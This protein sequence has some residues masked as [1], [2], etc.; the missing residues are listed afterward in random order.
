MSDDFAARCNAELAKFAAL[1]ARIT[2]LNDEL[3]H[4]IPLPRPPVDLRNHIRRDLFTTRLLIGG[5]PYLLHIPGSQ[6]TLADP[7]RIWLRPPFNFEAPYSCFALS[8][9]H[10]TPATVLPPSPSTK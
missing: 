10:L 7:G 1:Q 8:P 5:T 9:A 4:T 3:T 2:K 6:W